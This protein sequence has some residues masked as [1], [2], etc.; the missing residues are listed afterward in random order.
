MWQ[1][2][3]RCH[4]GANERTGVETKRWQD[5]EV[6]RVVPS[7]RLAIMVLE[8]EGKNIWGWQVVVVWGG[9]TEEYEVAGYG[10]GRF[11]WA[12]PPRLSSLELVALERRPPSLPRS[13]AST[14][15]LPSLT[16]SFAAY[17]SHHVFFS[18][19]TS[20]SFGFASPYISSW[21]RLIFAWNI[22]MRVFFSKDKHL[23]NFILFAVLATVF[24]MSLV[25][26]L[27]SF[28]FKK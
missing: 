20:R 12:D 22:C 10:S 7:V 21:P 8:R 14:P 28:F 6:Q 25:G 23:W 24:E 5:V 1:F 9:G 11:T 18:L 16:F 27:V 15:A 19:K 13:F 3:S 17:S 4:L 2:R 26:D